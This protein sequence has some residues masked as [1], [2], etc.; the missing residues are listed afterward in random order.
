MPRAS[1]NHYRS[2]PD[3]PRR[4]PRPVRPSR[5]HG[6]R[7]GR[8]RWRPGRPLDRDPA[9]AARSAARERDLG[10][11]ARE[12]FGARRAHPVGRHHGPARAQRT[13]ARL[14]GAGRAAEPAGHRRRDG[15][16]GRKGQPAHAQ[17]LPAGVL[18]EPRQLH[19]QPGRLHQVAGAA[20]RESRRR[21]L[22]RLPGRRGA[23]QRGRLG[24]R[25]GH[26]QHGHRQ[27]RRADRE[28][29]ARHGAAGQVHRVRAATWAAS[30]S[31]STSST[32]AR[33]RRPTAWA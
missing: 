9:Q 24:A 29:P 10:R 23:L 5:S 11:G 1:K 20:G 18:P 28:L 19:H 14:E 21:D 17:R 6:I 2:N 12:G 16:P 25:R 15:V 4:N 32:P 22:P 31:P 3:D 33:T 30:S 7:R 13:A 26:R 27:G 8:G